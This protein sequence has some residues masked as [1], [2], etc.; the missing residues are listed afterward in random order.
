MNKK[1]IRLLIIGI[2]ITV[3]IIVGV[4]LTIHFVSKYKKNQELRRMIK[5]YYNSKVETFKE[6]N[7]KIK[8]EG[9]IV[10]LVFLG[11]SITDNCDVS[12]YY[13]EYVSLNRGIGGDTTTGLLARMQE[14][15]YD[16]NCKVV[17]MC[18]GCN[19][20]RNMFDDYEQLLIGIKEHKPDAK[21]IIVSMPPLSLDYQGQSEAFID[22][23]KR[24]KEYA[25]QYGFSFVDIY[26]PLYDSERKCVKDGMTI[27]GV[28]PSHESYLIISGLVKEEIEKL[29][30]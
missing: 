19:N 10:D 25:I 2:I 20:Y 15:L 9:T 8:E 28:H 6:E 30:N 18:I 23:T 22:C 16:V 3:V 1:Q 11:D 5:E 14:S 26:Y 21:V 24:V 27:D 12:K 17:I 13:S 7:I 4:I 29:L